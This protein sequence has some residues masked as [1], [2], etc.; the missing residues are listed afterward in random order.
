MK[1]HHLIKLAFVL[2]LLALGQGTAYVAADGRAPGQVPSWAAPTTALVEEENANTDLAVANEVYVACDPADISDDIQTAVNTLRPIGGGTIYLPECDAQFL[3]TVGSIPANELSGRINIM[4]QGVG[5]TIL[6]SD[7]STFFDINHWGR[8]NAGFRISGISFYGLP[9]ESGSYTSGGIQINGVVDFRIDHCY[10]ER[11]QY[12]INVRSPEGFPQS[13]GVVDHCI[14]D[15]KDRS[16]VYGVYDTRVWEADMKLGSGEAIFIE[17]CTLIRM[18][19]PGASFDGG[20]YVLRNSVITNSVKIDAH[21]PGFGCCDRGARATEVYGNYIDSG[22]LPVNTAWAAIGLRAGGGVIF[23]NTIKRYSHYAMFTSDTQ[24]YNVTAGVYPTLDQPH[25][26]WLWDNTLIDMIDPKYD[27]THPDYEDNTSNPDRSVVSGILLYS[28]KSGILIQKDRD[29]FVRAPSQ[30]Q[31]G[32]TYRPYTYPHPLTKDVRLSAYPADQ[33]LGLSWE[34]GM[35]YSLPPATTWRIDYYS[36]A[37]ASALSVTDPFSLTRALTLTGLSS[38][39]TYT[40]TLY[41]L[42]DGTPFLSDTL[43]VMAGPTRLSG[44]SGDWSAA[45]AWAGGVVPGP[46]DIVVIRLGD[47]VTL[48][49]DAACYSLVVEPGGTLV[50]ATGVTLNAT[51]GIVNH[52]NLHVR[53]GI[54]RPSAQSGDWSTASTWEG[55][56][57]PGRDDDVVVSA[58]DA[59][60]LDADAQCNSLL[61][62]HGGTLVIPDGLTLTVTS[63]VVNRGTLR[64]TR[65]VGAGGRVGFLQL[66][67]GGDGV[68]YRGVTITTTEEVAL[69]AV[70]VTLHTLADGESCPAA[71]GF[72]AYAR[73]CFEIEAEHDL[74]A[75][76]RLWALDSELNEAT[77]KS[78]FR[79]VAPHWVKLDEK[80]APRDTLQPVGDYRYARGYT[81][82]FSHF[83]IADPDSVPAAPNLTLTGTPA[84]GAIHLSWSFTGTLPATS[85]WQIAYYTNGSLYPAIT[86]IISTTRS[87]VLD[88]LINNTWY[89]VTLTA[90]GTDPLL[91]ATVRVMPTGISVY[92]PLVMRGF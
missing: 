90:I 89:T 67:D 56:A 6:R 2:G 64:Q 91:S 61:V 32:F 17:D 76:V 86:G 26:V 62:E 66:S 58:G 44:G 34:T 84:N 14:F 28:N 63:G 4:G 82:G 13:R 29:F 68:H 10:F 49:A 77:M 81:P 46:D 75:A 42:L 51:Q 43:H 88:G 3:T 92:L 55:D 35:V 22:Q 80:F 65:P 5:K 52:G 48:T 11:I 54:S 74:E 83:L 85:T 15:A 20:H 71:S 9:P 87:Y 60:S 12:N 18:G 39:S 78:V 40:V 69:G 47:V 79:Y 24:G 25:D 1:M 19:H 33:A 30:E 36:Q 8:Y 59:V 23:N 38:Y 7:G 72:S 37:P 41:A 16:T 50:I 53:T 57:A 27:P 45:G 70:T 21:G 73:R 31:D